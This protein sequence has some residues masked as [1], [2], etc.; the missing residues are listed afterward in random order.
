MLCHERLSI[1]FHQH[2]WMP[3]FAAYRVDNSLDPRSKAF[4]TVN[5]GSFLATVA[6]GDLP[7][8]ELPYLVA[9]SMIH[10]II[11]VLEAWAGVEFSEERVEALLERY[12]NAFDSERGL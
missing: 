9:E 3:G 7:A 1:E 2:D 6:S 11:H 5:I 8:A 12:R 4:C 10:E